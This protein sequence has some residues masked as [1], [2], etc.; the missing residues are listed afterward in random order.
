MSFKRTLGRCL[1]A[2]VSA[3]AVCSMTAAAAHAAYPDRPIRLVV[4]FGAGTSPD[5]V[6]RVIERGLADR[7]GVP[8][9]IE[10]RAG[11]AGNIGIEY[12]ARTPADGYTLLLAGSNI[13]VANSIYRNLRFDARRDFAPVGMIGSVPSVLVVAANSK[14][15]SVADL[16]AY[17][18]AN[19]GKV[20]FASSGIGT[21]SHLAGEL[22]NRVAGVQMVH[23]PYP[24]AGRAM[25][26]IVAGRVDVLFDNLPA[27]VAQLKGGTTRALGVASMER[28]PAIPD[29]PTIDELGYRDFTVAPWYSVMAPAG[30]PPEVIDFL[31]AR[32]RAVVADPQYRSRLED[33]GL[34]VLPGSPEEMRRFVDAEIVK[35]GDLVRAVGI[36]AD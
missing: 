16:A 11:A 8:I 5:A 6:A 22:F 15:R 24:A 20:T 3:F 23:V 28:N 2:A 14:L 35:W 4:P 27:S 33:L 36:H 25:M 19:P 34:K 17:A 29:V 31:N 12:V 10:N 1:C 26:D 21:T 13:A 32:L 9:V 7:V 30:T 18:K